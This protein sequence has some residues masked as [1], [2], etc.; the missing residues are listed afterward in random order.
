[1]QVPVHLLDRVVGIG[2]IGAGDKRHIIAVLLVISGYKFTDFPV[3]CRRVMQRQSAEGPG[4]TRSGISR[5][6][7]LAKFPHTFRRMPVAFI[8]SHI[9]VTRNSNLIDTDDGV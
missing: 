8:R 9:P 6:H 2:K 1:V 5:F 4:N 7:R 3:I